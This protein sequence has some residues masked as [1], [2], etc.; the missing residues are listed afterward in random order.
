MKLA[1]TSGLLAGA[2]VLSGSLAA[3]AVADSDAPPS[4]FPSWQDVQ[5]AQQ[6]E[7][8]KAD[9]VTKINALLDGLQAQAEELGNA[10]VR[11]AA[12]YAVAKAALDTASA[13]VDMLTAQTQR[14][15]AQVAQYKK[16]SG[17]LAAQTYKAGGANLGIFA[18]LDALGS[19]DGLRRLD[20]MRIVTEKTTALF[21]DSRAAEGV[22]KAL[23]DQQEAAKAE[24]ERLAGAAKAKLDAAEAAQKAMDNQISQQKQQDQTLTAQLASLK[25]TSAVVEDQY[26]QGQAALAAYQAAQEAK[27]R[28]AEEQARQQAAA[29]AAAQAA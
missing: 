24:R 21:N 19:K 13:K 16:E 2:M 15:N 25:G 10:A 4:G 28:A 26:R 29:A 20:V 17:A 11:S 7:A 6:N 14:A 18:A 9:E 12:D 27:R 3:P 23:T 22:A 5:N 8:S 1:V